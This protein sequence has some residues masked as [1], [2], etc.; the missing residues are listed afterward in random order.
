MRNRSIK[1]INA[2]QNGSTSVLTNSSSSRGI[3]R[4]FKSDLPQPLQPVI[5]KGMEEGYVGFSTDALPFHYLA[6]QPNTHK[7]IPTQFAPFGELKFL[8]GIVRRWER[9]WQATPPKDSPAQVFKTFSLTSGRLH[10]KPL[11][12][13]AVAKLPEMR[14]EFKAMRRAIASPSPT[15]SRGPEALLS[16]VW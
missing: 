7:Q 2:A 14:Q 4:N 12:L 15:P 5:E 3:R 6:N 16:C 10:G 9:V 11:K 1:A 8:T 13:A